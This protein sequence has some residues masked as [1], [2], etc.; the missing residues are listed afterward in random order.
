MLI[1]LFNGNLKVVVMLI[2][3]NIST[4]IVYSPFSYRFLFDKYSSRVFFSIN[5]EISWINISMIYD[6]FQRFAKK[7]TESNFCKHC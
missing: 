5:I 7:K 3:L 6:K 4:T 1:V 2:L